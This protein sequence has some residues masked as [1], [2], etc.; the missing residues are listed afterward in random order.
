M[1]SDQEV[2][3]IAAPH[4]DSPHDAAAAVAKSAFRKGSLDNITATFVQFSWHSSERAKTVISD[5]KK[6]MKAEMDAEEDF[7][8][9][10]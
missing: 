7:D 1:L 9:F 6:R 5:R 4:F 2:V 8:M 10:A 3:D